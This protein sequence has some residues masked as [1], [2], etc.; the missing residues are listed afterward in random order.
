MANVPRRA[1]AVKGVSKA[2]QG[3]REHV[4]YASSAPLLPAVEEPTAEARNG[5]PNRPDF[6]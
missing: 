4:R 1:G 5:L 3:A 6:L 2:L